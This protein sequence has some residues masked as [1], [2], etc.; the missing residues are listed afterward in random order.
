[1]KRKVKSRK[2]LVS[3][4]LSVL[5][6]AIVLLS[7]I[8]PVEV[9]ASGERFPTLALV[10][11]DENGARH[12]SNFTP[13]GNGTFEAN[14]VFGT[15]LELN[16]I[17]RIDIAA[18]SE[19]P[20]GWH[21]AS[22]EITYIR[23]YT[24]M[25]GTY[26]YNAVGYN[27][28]PDEPLKPYVRMEADH[29]RI[30]SVNIEYKVENFYCVYCWEVDCTCCKECWEAEC[31]CCDV[32][33]LAP[34]KCVCC[35]KCMYGGT[36]EG[37]LLDFSRNP[38]NAN[39]KDGASNG[40]SVDVLKL[41][42]GTG[43][44]PSS[45]YGIGAEF[46]N[47]IAPETDELMFRVF[48]PSGTIESPKFRA[49]MNAAGSG[50]VA[51]ERTQPRNAKWMNGATGTGTKVLTMP[52]TLTPFTGAKPSVFAFDVVNV[53]AEDESR[54]LINS[55][56]LYG[57]DGEA[58]GRVKY[59]ADEEEWGDFM[60]FNC[61]ACEY[62]GA[63]IC[64]CPVLYDMWTVE[65][66]DFAEIADERTT[67]TATI[68]LEEPWTGSTNRQLW[69]WTDLTK[70][71]E[72]IKMTGLDNI[73]DWGVSTVRVTGGSETFDVT[74]PKSMLILGGRTAT[75]LFITSTT[76]NP[77]TSAD[78]RFDLIEGSEFGGGIKDV[79]LAVSKAKICD[80]CK[81]EPCR[82]CKACGGGSPM[83]NLCCN[84]CFL[85]I[86]ECK[87]PKC[88]FNRNTCPLMPGCTTCPNADDDKFGG[89]DMVQL[90]ALGTNG[91]N[92]LRGTS[93]KL[94]NFNNTYTAK[95]NIPANANVKEILQFGL[96]SEGGIFDFDED[97]GILPFGSIRPA[98]DAWG[99]SNLRIN[100]VR[101][102]GQTF[103]TTFGSSMFSLVG[104]T[105]GW[106]AE[107]GYVN[108]LMWNAY[109]TQQNRL[110]GLK[111]VDVAADGVDEL[112]PAFALP[113]GAN[114]TSI[115]VEFTT[116]RMPNGTPSCT[117]NPLTCQVNDCKN[118]KLGSFDVDATVRAVIDGYT[119]VIS[120]YNDDAIYGDF[121]YML[122]VKGDVEDV[123]AGKWSPG[124]LPFLIHDPV[125]GSTMIAGV[126][127]A[128][129]GENNE[130][131]TQRFDGCPHEIE[132]TGA[133]VS[134]VVVLGD[135]ICDIITVC[136]VCNKVKCICCNTC[137]GKPTL[138]CCPEC[139]AVCGNCPLCN[140]TVGSSTLY[141]EIDRVK[142]EV[143]IY[144][145]APLFEDFYF[146]FKVTGVEVYNMMPRPNTHAQGFNW[147]QGTVGTAFW[148]P[149]TGEMLYTGIMAGV[150][151]AGRLLTTLAY[152]GS[153][154]DIEIAVGGAVSRVVIIE[155]TKCAAPICIC[156]S[157]CQEVDCICVKC[158]ECG[159][160]L[161]RCRCCGECRKI[162]CVCYGLRAVI[163]QVAGVIRFVTNTDL[164][165]NSQS[166]FRVNIKGNTTGEI[167]FSKNVEGL[168]TSAPP[169]GIVINVFAK[170]EIKSGEVI[171]TQ[172]FSGCGREIRIPVAT[173]YDVTSVDGVC[174]CVKCVELAPGTLFD[175]VPSLN[176]EICAVTKTIRYYNDARI[177][178]DFG[179]VFDIIVSNNE[180]VL[181]DIMRPDGEYPQLPRGS[182]DFNMYNPAE[183]S[184]AIAGIMGEPI[185]S[186]QLIA[187]QSFVGTAYS[188]EIK[189]DAISVVVIISCD[190][191]LRAECV[192]CRDCELE[193]CE[194]VKFAFNPG[195][196]KGGDEIT[197]R[198]A[199][200]ILRYL[201]KLSSD[202]VTAPFTAEDDMTAFNAA[203]T[204]TSFGNKPEMADALQILRHLVKLESTL[205]VCPPN[206]NR[207]FCKRADGTK[208]CQDR[209][210][211]NYKL[212]GTMCGGVGDA[213]KCEGVMRVEI[214]ARNNIMR[215]FHDKPLKRDLGYSFL[216]K[217]VQIDSIKHETMKMIT[218]SSGK[219]VPMFGADGK[220]LNSQS[221][222]SLYNLENVAFAV[223]LE[224]GAPTGALV[225][226]VP[227]TGDPEDVRFAE[228]I[229]AE[230]DFPIGNVTIVR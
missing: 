119:G 195:S 108:F 39:M 80:G 185:G 142:D 224:Y 209:Q 46:T 107:R 43:I 7:G 42:D 154:S 67:V 159:D 51:V 192:C 193:V 48:T 150:W 148:N 115:E 37:G 217:G 175:P 207:S 131:A 19:I 143:R 191:C 96:L 59:D 58:L 170:K 197:M 83:C 73:T 60:S 135:C 10:I 230:H 213:C 18:V 55:V 113:N 93:V 41:I 38:I 33:N 11:T 227:F 52:E 102:N 151:P 218:D 216:I 104:Q 117:N 27:N 190:V 130:I 85:P 219:S 109:Y 156:C 184:A 111:V 210:C 160:A 180:T 138:A 228:Y 188:I 171:A 97:L 98:P 198:D 100:T 75:K 50:N 5:I 164:P 141:V 220:L 186:G 173:V 165:M 49:V 129:W 136:D 194:C 125:T 179:F 35:K 222:N 61:Y 206:C 91:D 66:I 167:A 103:T 20:S 202:I 6:A 64:V 25:S 88:T 89:R 152:E 1:M 105:N 124:S 81:E 214:D 133:Q 94:N 157:V 163:D 181:G 122:R 4:V 17:K 161:V 128:K 145:N 172:P 15:G 123:I 21:Y 9:S 8:P 121:S 174:N 57:E 47:I 12:A 70:T 158:E 146:S 225:A 203:R 32:C 112:V 120:Y 28:Y 140:S 144:N 23:V 139:G 40:V 44:Q 149:D 31:V 166:P 78:I 34:E 84:A 79:S 101:I 211:R 212:D 205:D 2:H 86:A 155:C 147:P 16:H 118:C 153:A 14:I 215:F 189:G 74:I 204:V 116:S 106:Y 169:Y 45:I 162:E 95:L 110:S 68:N 65:G 26:G 200:Q 168:V 30:W 99:L 62:C 176:V 76:F 13:Q 90:V 183:S 134:E 187:V 69:L 63:C 56:M 72:Q 137:G 178:S 201:V 223:I 196:L 53:R 229:G 132:I 22:I 29:N 226:F 177:V 208:K 221:T 92:L 82:C 36:I 199:L 71:P 114:I 87:C 24:R 3:R 77:I 126:M 54:A 182:A 127:M